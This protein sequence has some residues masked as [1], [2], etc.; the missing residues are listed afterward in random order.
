MKKISA[1]FFIISTYLLFVSATLQAQERQGRQEGPTLIM[2]IV[3]A[4]DPRLPLL[5][6]QDMKEVLDEAVRVIYAKFG[7]DIRIDFHDNGTM[8]LDEFFKSVKYGKP[9]WPVYD[10]ALGEKQTIFTDDEYKKQVMDFLKS[11]SIES[12]KGFVPDRKIEGYDQFYDALVETYHK[13][14][15]WQKTLKTPGGEPLVIDPLPPYQSYSEWSALMFDQNKY[16][17]VFTNGFIIYDYLTEPYPHT[18]FKHAKV[19]GSSF[20]SPKREPLEGKTLMVNII[21]NFGNIEG[22]SDKSKDIPRELKNKVLAGYYFAHEFGHAMYYLP[23][24]YDH[25]PSCL[26][27]TSTENMDAVQGYLNLIK[28]MTPCPKCRPWI[29]TRKISLKAK[30]EFDKGNFKEA[31]KLYL[32]VA[33]KLP[34]NLDIGYKS[35]MNYIYGKAYDSFMKSNNFAGMRKCQ[36]LMKALNEAKK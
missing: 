14:I 25:G 9:G 17:V 4:F 30:D 8:T 24:F 33:E 10:T 27:D 11:W 21:E 31:G 32:E 35:Y 12:L 16:D 34:H 7:P 18:V 36:E 15:K 20:T 19:G 1:V 29:E 6:D 26:M 2:E 23:D 28:D 22:I 3:R 5:S 13:K